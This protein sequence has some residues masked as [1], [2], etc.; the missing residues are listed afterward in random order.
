MLMNVCKLFF[1]DE[2]LM[3]GISRDDILMIGIRSNRIVEIS[4]V[5][6]YKL[7]WKSGF[8]LFLNKI[9]GVLIVIIFFRVFGILELLWISR[10]DRVWIMLLFLWLWLININ[11]LVEW[12][13]DLDNFILVFFFLNFEFLLF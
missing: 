2:I 12:W 4:K 9:I 13:I 6:M 1:R 5:C 10:F 3:I 7:N 11:G 8:L